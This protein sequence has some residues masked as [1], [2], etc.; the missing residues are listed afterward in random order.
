MALPISVKADN[1]ISIHC[2]PSEVLKNGTTSCTINGTSSTTI[3]SVDLN[4]VLDSGLEIVGGVTLPTGYQG[5]YDNGQISIYGFENTGTNWKIASFNLKVSSAGTIKL[6][7]VTF[8][9]S[10]PAI[11]TYS[12][13]NA[14][15]NLTIKEDTPVQVSGLKSFSASPG[16]YT[17]DMINIKTASLKLSSDVSTFK[18][19]AVPNNETDTVTCKNGHPNENGEEPL[20]NCNSIQFV[21]NGGNNNMLV[22]IYV[23]S[24][25]YI[26]SVTKEAGI[27]V[28]KP[29]L[30]TLTIGS[31]TVKL[32][33]GKY[34]Y[35]PIEL[36]DVSNYLVSWTLKD[37]ANYE[38]AYYGG[39]STTR[40][41]AGFVNIQIIPKDDSSGLNTV[42]YSIEVVETGK[43]GQPTSNPTIR[44]S[45]TNS[46]PQ[47]GGTS[48]TI[49]AVILFLSLG[50]S[51]YFYQ[52]NMSSYN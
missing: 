51:I 38:V 12:V 14:S 6:N 39:N 13:H 29:E 41:G 10:D 19:E 46:N 52:K 50:A 18:I 31:V 7:N 21:G 20:L 47:T 25:K 37:S 26:L 27:D 9:D 3:T 22:H 40:S 30:D 24:E 28:G 44:P 33:P 15:V 11:E 43:G 32:E 49:M 23:G 42:T 34:D 36:N 48:A 16:T 45:D 35:G 4:V 5:N 1:S 2:N 17:G 8:N